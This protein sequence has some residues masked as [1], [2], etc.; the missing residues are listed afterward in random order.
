[1]YSFYFAEV[2]Y[3]V[4]TK[5]EP[6]MTDPYMRLGSF[7]ANVVFRGGQYGNI[8]LPGSAE[9]FQLVPKEEEKYYVERTLAPGKTWREPTKVNRYVD[10]PPLLKELIKQECIDKHVPFADDE[11]KLPLIIK[12]DDRFSHTVYEDQK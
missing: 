7:Q 8:E 2:T 11:L 12:T 6:D 9:D 4:L 10:L 5:A 3:Y 1:M